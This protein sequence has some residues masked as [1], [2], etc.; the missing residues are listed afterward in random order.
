MSFNPSIHKT[1]PDEEG[2]NHFT[3]INQTFV[4]MIFEAFALLGARTKKKPN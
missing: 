1:L 3:G 2:E 4:F